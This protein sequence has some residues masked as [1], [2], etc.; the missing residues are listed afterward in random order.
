MSDS[1]ARLVCESS[2]FLCRHVDGGWSGAGR[3]TYCNQTDLDAVI[4]KINSTS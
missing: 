1:V 2:V 3:G 4:D